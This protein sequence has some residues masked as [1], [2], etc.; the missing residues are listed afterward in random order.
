MRTLA[1]CSLLAA[2]CRVDVGAG[3]LDP[4]AVDQPIDDRGVI[5][6]V[7]IAKDTEFLSE[8]QTAQI[9]DQFGK[10]LGAIDHIDVQVEELDVTDDAG[11]PIDGAFLTLGIDTVTLDGAKD[12][13]RLTEAVKQEALRAVSMREALT[14]PVQISVGWPPGEPNVMTAHAR[15]QPIV[16]VNALDAL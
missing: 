13:V 7:S 10:K 5:P 16:V 3:T 4:I 15:L 2:G 12:R 1:R 8:D 6:P 11:V 14:L 9:A